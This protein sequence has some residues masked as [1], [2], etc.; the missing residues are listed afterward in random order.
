M[1]ADPTRNT[2]IYA[3]DRRRPQLVEDAGGFCRG[4][5]IEVVPEQLGALVILRERPVRLS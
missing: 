3:G 1:I 2:A 5:D 4:P